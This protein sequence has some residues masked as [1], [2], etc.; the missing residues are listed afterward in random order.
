MAARRYAAEAI[1]TFVLVAGGVGTAVLASTN[2]GHIGV[3]FAFGLSLMVMVYVIGPI[4]GCHINPAVTFGMRLAGRVSTRDAIGY[5][6]AQII[7]AIGAAAVILVIAKARQGGYDIATGGLGANGYG[8]HSPGHYGL[9]GAIVAELVGT[10]LLVFTVLSVT[11][12]GTQAAVAGIPIGLVLTV[13]HLVTIPVDSTS[14]NP[15]RSIGPALFV[16]HWALSELWVFIVVPLA[17]GA[18][19][20]LVHHVIHSASPAAGEPAAAAPAGNW[21]PDGSSQVAG[22]ANGPSMRAQ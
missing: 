18:L 13:I 7:G 22:T 16:G 20:A 9:S 10:A 5:V 3:A 2:V 11:G 12:T 19:A 4:S 8:A 1:G 21:D 14:V 6:I 15:A 17:G